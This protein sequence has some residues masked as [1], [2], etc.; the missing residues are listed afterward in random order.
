MNQIARTLSSKRPSRKATNS[1]QLSFSRTTRGEHSP[2][3]MALYRQTNLPSSVLGPVD[4]LALARLA[5]TAATVVIRFSL[6][7]VV[8]DNI[9]Q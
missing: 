3:L 2:C 7:V 9:S 1:S 5:S 6:V 4:F 8:P